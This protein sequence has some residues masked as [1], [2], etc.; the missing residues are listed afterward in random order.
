MIFF[1][2]RILYA[3]KFISWWSIVFLVSMVCCFF[4]DS[5]NSMGSAL[6]GLTGVA[7]V[8]ASKAVFRG[9][10]ARQTLFFAIFFVV[11]LLIY[12]VAV[13]LVLSLGRDLTFTG[14][15]RIWSF[16][17]NY[18]EQRPALG[19]GWTSSAANEVFVQN[20]R[21]FLDLPYIRSAHSAYI[22]MLVELGY[23]GLTLYAAW[24]LSTLFGAF[25]KA[26]RDNDELSLV[27]GAMCTGMITF[28]FF[29]VSGGFIPSLWLIL[30]VTCTVSRK[31]S[32]RRVG[33]DVADDVIRTLGRRKVNM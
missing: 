20:L 32:A 26:S 11:I 15:T 13:D 30:V 22:T 5:A 25:G 16:Y 8:K 23:F 9:R 10:V 18:V 21:D 1:G 17:M 27:C 29:E 7:M 14:R 4:S 19:W 24:L 31:F 28:G 12:F 33:A 6:A 3:N 2:T